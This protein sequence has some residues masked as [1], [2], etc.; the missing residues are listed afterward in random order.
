MRLAQLHEKQETEDSTDELI[1][2][3][4]RDCKEVIAL[5]KRTN[6]VF[7]RG[8]HQDVPAFVSDIR[9]NRKPLQVKKSQHD[10]VNS[11]MKVLGLDVTRGNAIFCSVSELVAR[12]WGQGYVIFPKDGWKGLVFK[13]HKQGYVFHDLNDRILP[14]AKIKVPVFPGAER[15]VTAYDPEYIAS[16]LQDLKPFQFTAKNGDEVLKEG[17][18]D[19]LIT[20][21]GYYAV[22]NPK[23]T[24]QLHRTD[25]LKVLEALGLEVGN[26]GDQWEVHN[27]P[28]QT[29][30]VWKAKVLKKYPDAKFYGAKSPTTGYED[31]EARLEDEEGEIMFVG[32]A[33][34]YGDGRN[35]TNVFLR[36]KDSA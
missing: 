2:K 17:Y 35:Y 22:M 26:L 13:E 20:G 8:E 19:V 9:Q 23:G 33:E 1:E 6:K 15:K 18:H 36:P 32:T 21:P 29:L 28:E 31:W 24:S 10:A 14:K 4:K 7:L 34:F 12:M 16:E 11:A 25:L 3:I 30:D 5:Y 27:G